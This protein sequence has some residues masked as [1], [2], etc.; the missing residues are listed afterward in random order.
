MLISEMNFTAKCY[1]K[2]SNYTVYHTNHPAG[3]AI[4]IKNSIKHHQPN[5]YSQDFL[6]ATSVSVEDSV[7]LL[8]ISAVYLPPIYTVKQAQLE[9][10]YNTLGRQFIEGG[11]Y[12]AK[13]DWGSRLITPRGRQVLKK[14]KETKHLSMG[15]PTYWP[16]D[17]NKLPDLV[18]FC[19]TKGL[20]EDFA[21]AESCFDLSSVHCLALITLT[22]H[23]LEQEKQPGLSNRHTNRD[24][25]RHLINERLTLNVS[26]K[27]E[28]DIEAAIKFF[29]NS[30][31]WAGWNAM[32]DHRDTRGMRL[33]YIN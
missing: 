12:N 8:T 31:Q 29:S 17:R 24:D 20:P 13:H 15:E 23:A 30:I 2:L 25:F 7:G 1:L 28:G 21:V 9:Y 3:S 18:D 5:N 27:T 14:W 10:F 22:A 33:P 26:L 4:I 16:S 6:Q 32:P 11:D 19:V